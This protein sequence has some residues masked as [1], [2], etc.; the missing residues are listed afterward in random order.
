MKKILYAMLPALLFTTACKKGITDINVNPKSPLNVPSATVFTNAERVLTNTVTS[1]SVNLNI[2]RLI[3][4]QW[5]ETTYTDESNYDISTRPIPDAIWNAMYRDVLKNLEQVKTLSAN[6][7]LSATTLNANKAIT[8]VL[9]VYSYYYLLTTFGNIPY[10]QALND[11][12]L[13]PKYDD[14]K[15][16]YYD[17]LNRLD[18]D[19]AVLNTGSSSLG[20]ADIIYGGDA[21]KWKLFANTFKLKMGITISDIDDAKAKTTVESAVAAG[22]FSS[23]S[24]N[25]YFQYLSAPPNTNPI[26]VDLVQ[27]GRKDYVACST[28][29]NQLKSTNDPRLPFYF[30]LDASGGYSGAAPGASSNYTTF[31]KPSAT[32]TA[33]D[34]PGLLLS[35]AETEFNL[36][37]A[38]E[39]GYN[40]GGTAATHY[41]NGITA[42]VL[43]WKG[44]QNSAELYIAQPAINYLTAPGTF[45][46]KIG[47]QKWLALY[48]RG[49]DA[50]IEQRRLDYPALVA[51]ATALSAYPFRFTYPVN[52]GNTNGANVTAAGT[53]I[54]GNLVTTKLFFDKF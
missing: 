11:N 31:S 38:I 36:A 33:P 42:S 19:I 24:N 30:T 7:G 4:Q 41:N 45:K 18:A 25:A 6:E 13:F 26:W 48:N 15:T 39:R 51:P 20:S 49:W 35:Y 22:V 50:W 10:T 3:E 37:E 27:S 40:V 32:I 9:E 54:G 44:T 2:F 5:Q 21:T 43:Q 47:I 52:E 23:N 16:V 12:V 8:D 34:F 1:S 14:A 53:A 17:L 29:M 46:Q 28:L